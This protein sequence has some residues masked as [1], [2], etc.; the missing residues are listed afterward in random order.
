[1]NRSPANLKHRDTTSPES[2][3]AA[4]A[5]NTTLRGGN[6]G[7]PERSAIESLLEIV[8][9]LHELMRQLSE[10]ASEKLAAMRAADAEALHACAARECAVLERLFAREKERDAVLA[11]L[12]QSLP[13]QEPGVPRLSAIAEKIPEPESSRLQAKIAGLRQT[14]EELQRKNRLA[15]DVAQRLHKHIRA[16][17][18][19]IAGVNQDADVY[20]PGG[21]QE[22]RATKTWVDAVG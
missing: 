9:A 20:G 18:E 10:L 7:F 22:P 1:M 21:R 16:I 5:P 17:F 6:L 12:A 19:E 15:A 14:A 11:R 3:Q 4:G 8:G 13:W 2:R